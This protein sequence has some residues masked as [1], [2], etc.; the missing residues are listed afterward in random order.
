M[1]P[2]LA[3]HGTHLSLERWGLVTAW[4]YS[5]ALD[6]QVDDKFP[7]EFVSKW[8]EKGF[9]IT[10]VVTLPAHWA[11]VMSQDAGFE[12]Q[13][14]DVSE[15]AHPFKSTYID[16]RGPSACEG[17]YLEGKSPHFACLDDVSCCGYGLNAN[18]TVCCRW[19]ARA[20]D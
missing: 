2:P 18:A 12:D 9:Y 14:V 5:A 3:V 13:H 11:V 10:S 20:D 19:R 1:C 15:R 6:S 17:K 4:T 16:S 8:W 7:S